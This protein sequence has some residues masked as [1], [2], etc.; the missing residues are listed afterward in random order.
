MRTNSM[1]RLLAVGAV[2]LLGL[3]ACTAQREWD[4][5]EYG[6]VADGKTVNTAA[7]QRAIDECSAAGGGTV[8]VEG[9]VFVS[10]SLLIK[11]NVTFHVSKSTTLQA[12]INPNDYAITDPFLDATGQF[13]GHSLIGMID[14]KNVALTGEGTIDGR[15]DMFY[16]NTMRK[17]VDSLG[18]TLHTYDFSKITSAGSLYVAKK[19]RMTYR[20]FLV[21]IS[22]AVGV[23]MQDIELRQPGAW[24]CHL[25]QTR[26]FDIDGV[27]IFS[28]ANR[29]NDGIDIDSSSDGVIRNTH[30]DSGDDA[31]CFK[32]T[33][34]LPSQNILVEHCKL[35]SRWGAIKF[36]TESMGDFRDITVRDCHIYDTLGG[37]IKML[38]VD[39]ANIDNVLI[40]NLTM[41]NVDMPLFMR[42]GERRLTY[43]G[44]ERRPAGSIS[45]ITIRN[46]QA[47]VRELEE[48]RMKPASAIYMTGTKNHQ[49]GHVRLENITIELPGGGQ[50][51]DAEIVVPENETQYP[52]YTF[53]GVTP[54]YGIYGRHMEAIEASNITFALRQKDYRSESK[55]VDV[56][57]Q[58]LTNISTKMLED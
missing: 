58:T 7:I 4:V 38:S 45:N 36:G 37:G 43:R 27:R 33:S 10:G 25:F 18:I 46:I 55:F 47:S 9:G 30:I 56:G 41:E 12:S 23:K 21:R 39:G 24:T 14:V 42:L 28:H 51:K 57:S 19:V 20:P 16:E 5:R 54:S 3:S 52:E 15:G 22:R 2:A 34:P 48:C 44:A 35:K 49:I 17:T 32:S 1:V 13:R 26:D 31:I 6:A 40:E 53:L 29:N 50:P 11:D 8:V